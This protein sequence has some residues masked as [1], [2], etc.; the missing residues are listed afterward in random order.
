MFGRDGVH[1]KIRANDILIRNGQRVDDLFFRHPGGVS[2]IRSLAGHFA[3]NVIG[4]FDDCQSEKLVAVL[5]L[6]HLG[7]NFITLARPFL[8]GQNDD[9]FVLGIVGIYQTGHCR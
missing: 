6:D 4:M 7:D 3:G 9:H 1:V 5:P 2:A 8:L